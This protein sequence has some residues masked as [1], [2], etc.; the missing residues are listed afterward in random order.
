MQAVCSQNNRE[1]LDCRKHHEVHLLYIRI[2]STQHI[3]IKLCE[4]NNNNTNKNIN[5]TT[6]TFI[7]FL[8]LMHF[9]AIL[10]TIMNS[11]YLSFYIIISFYFY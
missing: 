1:S 6:H 10:F 4:T 7:F 2:T 5:R 9:R 11:M 8:V 3:Y